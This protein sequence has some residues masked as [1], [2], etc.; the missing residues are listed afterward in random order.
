MSDR[1]ATFL[2][3]DGAP[4][5]AFR[6]VGRA[7]FLAA[8]GT[9]LAAAAILALSTS[10]LTGAIRFALVASL[11]VYAALT[12]WT[13]RRSRRRTIALR[14]SLYAAALGAM[15]LAGAVAVGL[16]DGLRDPVLGMLPLV[17]C[18][19]GAV[20]SVR[21]GV[22]L[23]V[24]AV[25]ELL[26]LALLERRGITAPGGAANPLSLMFL[27]QCLVIGGALASGALVAR[28]VAHYLAAAA[29]R[30]RKTISLLRLAADLHWEQDREFR[31]THV[32]DPHGLIDEAQLQA[33]IGCTPWQTKGISMS[34]AQLDAHRADLE[35]H[36]PFSGLLVRRHDA[37]GRSRVYSVSGEPRFGADGAFAGYW[38]VARDVTE[39]LRAQRASVAS[40]TRYREL[41]ERSPSP[42]YLHRRGVIYDANPAAARLFGFATPEAMHGLRLIDLFAPAHQERVAQRIA[43][44][45]TLPVGQ[46]TP[47]SDFQ[48]RRADGRRINVQA[49]GVRVDSS[50]GPATLS[51]LFDITARE[52]A[53]A[54]LRRSEAMLSHLVATSPDCITLSELTSGRHAMVNAAFTRLTGYAADE[55]VGKTATEL[56]L[57]RDLRDRDRLRAAMEASGRIDE[58]P[59]TLQRRSG[60]VASVLVSAARFRMDGRDYM[61]VN[62]RDV[63]ESERTRLEHAAILERA[64]IG[65]ALTRDRRF[66]QAN[67]R[68]EAIFGWATGTMV[69]EPGSA[70]W[71]DADDYAE[72]GRV[73]GPV[74]AAGAP[75]EIEREMRRKDGSRFWCRILG[76]PVDPL[77]PDQGGTIWIADDITERRRLDAALAAARDAAEAASRAKSAFLANTS[78][79]IRT[80][81]NGLLGLARL[82]LRESI[83]GAVRRQYLEQIF[84]SAR[85]LEGIL[86]DI[87]D[88]SKIEAGKF[89]LDDAVFD[90]RETLAG[91][92]ASYRS[93][94]EAKDLALELAVDPG[95]PPRVRGDPVRVRQILG[96]FITNAVKF[97]AGG[98]VRIEAAPSE[99]GVR[100]AVVDSGTGI[101]AAHLDQLFQPFS[102]GDASTTRRFGGTGLGLSICRQLARLMGGEVGVASSVGVG[103]TF[104][105]ELPLAPAEAGSDGDDAEAVETER[106]RAARVLLVE[107]NPVNM[108]IAAATLAQWGI[109]VEEARDGRMAIAA[110]E[111]AARGGRPFDLV[112]MDVQ[113]PVMSGHEA[114]RELRK[115]WSPA[116]LPIIALTAAALV[117]ERELALASGMNDFLT[118]PIDGPKLRQVLARHMAHKDLASL[119]AQGTPLTRLLPPQ[120]LPP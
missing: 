7:C 58:M 29:E 115:A 38:G 63:T 116:A 93:L 8:S 53:E 50:G 11:L 111:A 88:F 118:K 25:A 103:S 39:E 119:A 89:T 36:R 120:P 64:S 55:V 33:Q 69:G 49:T 40:E 20:A 31:F 57:W 107:D 73:A 72:I 19:M 14:E 42:L 106:L 80:P 32:A 48:A 96:N 4:E 30:E 105:A 74:L 78:H 47:V 15:L 102:Q 66:V 46:G 16:R 24:A 100:L 59:A 82:A 98:T 113:M 77:R 9:A 70:V 110:V 68:W 43:E 112:L 83:D 26:V 21:I 13:C 86:S 56:G 101:D 61:V 44:L 60:G 75:F 22:V 28:V 92:H 108:M 3:G 94:A 67:P 18:V 54:A 27:L 6:I 117:S 5:A 2:G 95:L 41:F 45:E 90:L 52:A 97:T 17:V 104:W 62:A 114:T 71:L 76:Q 37:Q 99:A 85:G 1:S 81:L 65:I 23:A 12:A 10:A 84:E 91:V 109:D 34:A 35:A 51:I 79:E 87:L